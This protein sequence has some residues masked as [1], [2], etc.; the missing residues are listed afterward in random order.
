MYYAS[1]GGGV[2]QRKCIRGRFINVMLQIATIFTKH[3]YCPAD[4]SF[5][6]EDVYLLYKLLYYKPGGSKCGWETC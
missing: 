5:P 1:E 2:Y 4:L 6:E 3:G